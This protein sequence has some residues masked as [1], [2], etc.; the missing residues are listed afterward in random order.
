MT[1]QDPV[2]TGG[3]PTIG[4]A[5][6]QFVASLVDLDEMMIA[7]A[8]LLEEVRTRSVKIRRLHQDGRPLGDLRKLDGPSLVQLLSELNMRMDKAGAYVR[9][10]AVA[11]LQ[12]EGFTQQEIADMFGVTRQRVGTLVKEHAEHDI[13]DTPDRRGPDRPWTD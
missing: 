4:P 1:T 10:R 8:H 9:R 3:A 6:D 5:Y 2:G 13:D 12:E 11:A 7:C